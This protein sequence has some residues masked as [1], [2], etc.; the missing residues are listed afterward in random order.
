MPDGQTGTSS[1]AGARQ[2]DGRTR[3]GLGILIFYWSF[4]VLGPWFAYAL[5]YPVVLYYQFFA[6]KGARASSDYLRRRFPELGWFALWR[7]RYRHFLSFGRV[8]VDRTY[9]FLG[10][11]DRVRIDRSGDDALRDALAQGK[12]VILLSA[13]IGNWELAAWALSGAL[14]SRV[15]VNAVMFKGE[16]ERVAKQLSR[17]SGEAPF[18]VIESND[19]LNASIR[20][21]EA[22]KR[23][24][25][26]AM[27]GDRTLGQPGVKAEFLGSQ[28]AFTPG[29]YVLAATT[30][31]PVFF[32][33]SNRTGPRRYRLTLKGPH[34]FA[35]SSR[36][37]RE[38]EL[39]EWAGRYARA[40]EEVL[41][42]FPLQWHN[43]Y[44]FWE[45]E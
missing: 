21:I 30:G 12:G 7:M 42:E 27:H 6:R 10:L 37:A 35:F 43:F 8:L 29:P 2:W 40:I 24:E 22:L 38:A 4:R 20:C 15:P 45:Q 17:A 13:H 19:S 41:S 28:A 36:A 39:R 14:Q 5:L 26:V 32:V 34:Y 33:F 16:S 23:G 18:Q 3:T 25:I 44:M 9:A 31:A 11:L 1:N